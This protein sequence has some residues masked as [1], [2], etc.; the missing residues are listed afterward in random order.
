MHRIIFDGWKAVMGA[1]TAGTTVYSVCR[2][3]VYALLAAFVAGFIAGFR[4][5]VET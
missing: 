5:E 1:I 2:N 3:S 4:V